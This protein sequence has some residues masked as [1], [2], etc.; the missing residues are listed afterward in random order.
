M[1]GVDAR[2]QASISLID[3]VRSTVQRLRSS[4]PVPLHVKRV[5][6]VEVRRLGPEPVHG[7]ELHGGG[8]ALLV[9]LDLLALPRHERAQNGHDEDEHDDDRHANDHHRLERR[10][11]R[12]GQSRICATINR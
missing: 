10:V 12:L 6:I 7:G 4:S 11:L 5:L 1:T 3:S 2:T 9:Q 8:H